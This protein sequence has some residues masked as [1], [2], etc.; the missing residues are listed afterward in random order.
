[1]LVERLHEGLQRFVFGG[2]NHL[3]QAE[4]WAQQRLR[5]HSGAVVLI[6]AG[7]LSIPLLIDER[8]LLLPAPGVALPDVTITLPVDAPLRLIADRQ[9]L[10][11]SVKLAGSADVAESL[12]FVF[13]HLRWDAEADLAV[14]VGD[15]AAH[16]VA[17]I[18]TQFGQTARQGLSRLGKGLAEYATEESGL[19]APV[20]DIEHFAREVHL[21]RDDLARLEKRIGR[22]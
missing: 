13:R 2:L 9:G 1:M 16:R 19:L 12:G 22:L 17:G 21:L 18:A 6:E 10:M 14:L 20:R 8:G 4:S 15:I 3:L 11:S 7:P 5:P